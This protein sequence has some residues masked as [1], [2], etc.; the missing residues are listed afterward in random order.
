M[1]RT[2]NTKNSSFDQG[3]VIIGM[4]RTISTKNSSF[5]LGC[6]VIRNASDY[7]Y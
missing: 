7:K 4:C 2:I 5:D 6:R 3:C 1:R